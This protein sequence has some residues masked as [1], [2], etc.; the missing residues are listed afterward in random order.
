MTEFYIKKR[1]A[2]TQVPKSHLLNYLKGFHDFTLYKDEL[3]SN[4][5]KADYCKVL[6]AVIGCM[7]A[8]N[9]VGERKR[10]KLLVQESTYTYAYY[11]NKFN[12]NYKAHKKLAKTLAKEM[13]TQLDLEFAEETK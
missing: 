3:K 2:L 5:N 10:N 6:E 8:E 11:T 9:T 4:S 12:E 7:Y 13:T 1:T